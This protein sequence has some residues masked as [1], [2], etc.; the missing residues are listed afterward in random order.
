MSTRA[1]WFVT[2][3]VRGMG[4]DIAKAALAAGHQVVATGA[5]ANTFVSHLAMLE[6]KPDGRDP[7]TWLE[8]VTDED[9]QRAK[10]IDIP[11]MTHT[12]ASGT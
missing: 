2:G 9:Y 5:A 3:A 11:R 8:P 7:T 6:A 1:V 12:S 10:H 4:V